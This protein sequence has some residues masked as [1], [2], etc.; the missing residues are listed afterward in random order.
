MVLFETTKRDM[1]F[2]HDYFAGTARHERGGLKV[3]LSGSRV[4]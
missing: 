4:D 3:R 2:V 1:E